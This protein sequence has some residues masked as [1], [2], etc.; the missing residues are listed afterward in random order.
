[1][2]K[3]HI[4]SKIKLK[5]EMGPFKSIGA[6]CTVRLVKDNGEI[7]FGGPGVP[8]YGAMSEDELD[9]YFEIVDPTKPSF[10]DPENLNDDDLNA[11]VEDLKMQLEKYEKVA[12]ER[13]KQK[14][15]VQLGELYIGD[16]FTYKTCKYIVV[17]RFNDCSKIAV[18]PVKSIHDIIYSMI[19]CDEDMLVEI[20]SDQV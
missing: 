2:S 12:E 6:I 7:Q 11:I 14:N 13:K 19:L 17:R 15:L 5:K 8:E 20:P 16:I 18:C 4:G 1:M 3:V 10:S 9:K